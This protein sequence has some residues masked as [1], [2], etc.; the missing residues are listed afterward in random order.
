MGAFVE[1][2]IS[3]VLNAIFPIPF[4]F[5]FSLLS[6]FFTFI[7]CFKY[8]FGFHYHGLVSIYD[9]AIHKYLTKIKRLA[10]D[11]IPFPSIMKLRATTLS[12]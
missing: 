8:F 2:E 5:P 10:H 12:W 9:N 1:G 11:E 3:L 4:V 6:S 7:S